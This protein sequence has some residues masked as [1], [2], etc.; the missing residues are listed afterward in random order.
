MRCHSSG[1]LHHT[2]LLRK[3]VLGPHWPNNVTRK[4]PNYCSYIFQACG[5]SPEFVEFTNNYGECKI[6]RG[7]CNII[8]EQLKLIQELAIHK[9]ILRPVVQHWGNDAKT[10]FVQNCSFYF[11]VL[12]E[13]S[14]RRY[15]SLD[16]GRV[17]IWW[18]ASSENPQLVWNKLMVGWAL[19]RNWSLTQKCAMGGQCD[20]M[21][22][23]DLPDQAQTQ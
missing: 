13:G 17:R 19:S 11:F 15:Q 14:P 23:A 18:L 4:L 6:W 3:V 16:Y 5:E 20:I 21:S 7:G 1:L 10:N 12:P 8:C 2:E 22:E 9:P